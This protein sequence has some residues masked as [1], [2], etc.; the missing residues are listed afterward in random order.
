MS[1]PIV[2]ITG[3]G[4]GIGRAIAF[5]FAREGFHVAA[6]S[7]SEAE[8]QKTKSLVEAAGGK[9]D[10]HSIDFTQCTTLHET[11]IALV[12]RYER[13]DVLVNNAGL[14]PL[15]RIE[16][17]APALF[18]NL[19]DVNVSAVYQ[20]CRAVWPLMRRTGKGAIV[21]ISSIASND[22]FAGFAA[23]GASKAWVNAW[24]KGLAEEGRTCG[25]RVF[26][27]APAGVETRM[28]RDAFPD[29]PSKDILAPE[30][31]AELVYT[32]TLPSCKYATGQTVF[33]RRD[34]D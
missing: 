33:I 9:C 30:D 24:T 6:I 25:I 16:E 8:L 11:L 20:M 31:V 23:Y 21:N 19:M 1:S 34:G 4:R 3:A 17:L 7:R 29:Y 5:R 28:L 2:L 12:A 10:T 22:A 27:V 13:I 26:A 15:A 32:L 14:A 18:Q